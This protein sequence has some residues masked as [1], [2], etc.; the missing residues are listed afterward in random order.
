[1]K[2]LYCNCIFCLVC[3]LMFGGLTVGA[4]DLP[5]S[6]D[7]VKKPTPEML[8]QA[9]S[10][11]KAR[12]K[13]FGT[14]PAATGPVTVD[15]LMIFDQSAQKYC[16]NEALNGHRTL[17]SFAT[18][19]IAKM[20]EVLSNSKITEFTYK[21]AGVET[22]EADYGSAGCPTTLDYITSATRPEFKRVPLKRK[23]TGADVMVFF[24]DTGTNSGGQANGAS[25][26]LEGSPLGFQNQA[27]SVC[28]I[29][30]SDKGYT[31]AHEVAT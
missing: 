16:T 18:A 24:I 27:I 17:E 22:V 4:Q 15:V 14:A 12:V 1:M 21:L 20:N 30:Y 31:T 26:A 2:K 10:L 13:A 23:L 5:E 8:Q 9:R 25:W 11:A 19:Q 3:L 28:A 29:R 7:V 6:W